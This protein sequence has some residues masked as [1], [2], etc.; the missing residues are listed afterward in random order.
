M[1]GSIAHF[2]A[3]IHTLYII[4]LLSSQ[5]QAK[6]SICLVGS[7]RTRS[8]HRLI[9]QLFAAVSTP[10]IAEL[11]LFGF[12]CPQPWFLRRSEHILPGKTK[13]EISIKINLENI[14]KRSWPSGLNIRLHPRTT[15]VLFSARVGIFSFL[16]FL[17][18]FF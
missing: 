15:R 1:E 14:N 7:V 11:V 6:S 4:I 3:H 13:K 2:L 18:F 10:N 16:S 17:F 12:F 9:S 8:A 5:V